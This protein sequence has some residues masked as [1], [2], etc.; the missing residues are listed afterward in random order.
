MLLVE[1]EDETNSEESNPELIVS[2][3]IEQKLDDVD[4]REDSDEEWSPTPMDNDPEDVLVETIPLANEMHC[5]DQ[6]NIKSHFMFSLT[7]HVMVH[8]GSKTKK[9]NGRS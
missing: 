3:R 8:K 9:G 7:R 1:D 4:F 2:K 6:C 5:C